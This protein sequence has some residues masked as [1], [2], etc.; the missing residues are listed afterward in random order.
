MLSE[1]V[2]MRSAVIIIFSSDAI[3]FI[4]N[5]RDK[6]IAGFLNRNILLHGKI[7]NYL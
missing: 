3:N 1:S 4:E 7:L 2:R 6:K 5:K